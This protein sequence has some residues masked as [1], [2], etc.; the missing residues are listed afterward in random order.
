MAATVGFSSW[1][2]QDYVL[3]YP[4]DDYVDMH[5]YFEDVIAYEASKV[6]DM[7]DDDDSIGDT[8][9]VSQDT[10]MNDAFLTKEE[11]IQFLLRYGKSF[12][13]ARRVVKN[14]KFGWDAFVEE[15]MFFDNMQNTGDLTMADASPDHES[16]LFLDHQ[17]V[18]EC[19]QTA[20]R[21]MDMTKQGDYL[22]VFGNTP[23]FV[24]RALEYLVSRITTDKTHR[25]VVCIP[26]SG[27]PNTDRESA[28][29]GG[30]LQ[31]G[32]K[33]YVTMARY[34]T[35]FQFLQQIIPG[36]S[37]ICQFLG[38]RRIPREKRIENNNSLKEPVVYIIDSITGGS[39]AAFLA[40]ILFHVMLCKNSNKLL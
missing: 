3:Q 19:Y 22:L 11:M 1:F 27:T 10:T 15:M 12:D 38:K 21:I 20:I 16:C 13:Y 33:N 39:G 14:R 7:E 17:T 2:D 6:V 30:D 8:K 9:P 37:T 40:R 4:Y 34:N 28:R 23:F 36:L 31:P 29:L 5:E 26:F 25:I 18:D 35:Y 24:G 32:I